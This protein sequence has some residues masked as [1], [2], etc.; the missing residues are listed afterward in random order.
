VS[1]EEVVEES[2]LLGQVG[3]TR[4]SSL[5]TDLSPP[6]LGLTIDD[7]DIIILIYFLKRQTS[8]IMN[9][10]LYLQNYTFNNSALESDE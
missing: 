7:A 6:V 10:Y 4:T 5:A 3:D 8:S 9:A 1:K 2:C